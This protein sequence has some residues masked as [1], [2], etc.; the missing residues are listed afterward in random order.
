MAIPKNEKP[1]F[2]EIQVAGRIDPQRSTWFENLMIT[3]FQSADGKTLTRL[4]GQLRDQAA[5]FG[6][7]MRIR[8]MGL[9]LVSVQLVEPI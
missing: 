8:D 1:F 2:Y 9:K 5:L 4:C 7:L 6:V 3:T